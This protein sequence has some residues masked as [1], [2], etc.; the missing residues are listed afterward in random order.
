[1]NV[2]MTQSDL[3][4]IATV[5]RSVLD[6]NTAGFREGDFNDPRHRQRIAY[7]LEKYEHLWPKRK[8]AE[9]SEPQE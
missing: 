6:R 7:F 4:L 1:M 2:K 3:M 9:G 8:A 5:L